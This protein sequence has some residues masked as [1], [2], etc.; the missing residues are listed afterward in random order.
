MVSTVSLLGA[1][2]LGEVV[3]NKPASLLVSL[4]KA[5]NEMY[6]PL[7]ERQVARHFK[8]G[9]SQASVDVRPKYND[10]IRFLEN[11]G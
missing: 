11:G 7:C 1:R 5:L 8:N 9:N 2:H 3:K 6:P 4:V 10:T